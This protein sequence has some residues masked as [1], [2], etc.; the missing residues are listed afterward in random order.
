[1]LPRLKKEYSWGKVSGIEGAEQ[2]F[3]DGQSAIA[4]TGFCSIPFPDQNHT[5]VEGFQIFSGTIKSGKYN[6]TDN[7]ERLC[8]IAHQWQSVTNGLKRG[9]I[10]QNQT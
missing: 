8:L 3:S 10:K 7:Q 4:L 6:M 9:S 5:N 2:D 1:M